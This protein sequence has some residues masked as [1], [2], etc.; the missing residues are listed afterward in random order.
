M[1]DH[2]THSKLLLHSKWIAYDNY[3]SYNAP[4]VITNI[5]NKNNKSGL[6]RVLGWYFSKHFAVVY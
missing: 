6:F 2:L 4:N 3:Y 5:G 1:F